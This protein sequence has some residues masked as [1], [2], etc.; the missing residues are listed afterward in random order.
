MA[1]TFQE[2]VL[3]AWATRWSWSAAFLPIAAAY[4][5]AIWVRH[6]LYSMRVLTAHKLPV[7][8]VTVG[9]VLA[10]GAG[11]TPVTIAI[12]KHLMRKGY[13]IGVVS[14]GYG[15]NTK[16]TSEVNTTSDPLEVGDE[17]LLIKHKLGC[18]VFVGAQRYAAARALL[19]RHPETQLVLC[20]DGIQHLQLARDLEVYVFDDRG[21]GNGWL[22]PAGPMRTPWPPYH[23]HFH[24]NLSKVPRLLLSTSPQSGEQMHLARR[25]IADYGVDSAG[26]HVSLDLLRQSQEPCL[27]VAGIA[28][29]EVF[30]NQLRQLGL[31]VVT[32]QALPDH[33]DFMDWSPPCVQHS[34]L[35]CTEKDA[36]KIWRYAPQTL[37]VP[38]QMRIAPGF[39]DALDRY[40]APILQE[41]P[42]TTPV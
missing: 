23:R 16:S 35:L 36:Q 21:L 24:H 2:T 41:P 32:T 6:C 18:P 11:K 37:A 40:L 7:T 25:S 5:M 30:F 3:R 13:Q 42:Q 1:Y 14:R 39:F 34:W 31:S 4:G 17:P 22:L 10:G 8:V 28:R 15:R 26:R 29:P 38:L 20:D 12:G 19:A 33:Y 9:N 27:A